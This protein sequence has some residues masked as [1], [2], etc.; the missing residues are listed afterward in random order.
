MERLNTLLPLCDELLSDTETNAD[1]VISMPTDTFFLDPPTEQSQLKA[2][3]VV[4]YFTAWSRVIQKWETPMAYVDLFCGPGKYNDGSLSTPLQIVQQTL[5]DW[6]LSRK[7]SFTF[8]DCDE[9][10]VAS[11]QQS[12]L[13]LD[14]DNKLSKRISYHHL[15]VE[16]DFYKR[17]NIPPGVPVLSFVDPFGYEGVTVRLI[18]RLIANRGSDCIFF[19]N[20]NRINMALSNTKFDEHLESLFGVSRTAELKRELSA[21]SPEL[22]E[23]SILNALVEALLEQKGNYVLPFKFYSAQMKRTSHFIIFVTKHP[24]AC[25]IMKNIMYANSA[26]DSDGVATF[27]LQD[28][29]NFGDRFDQISMFN[30][31]FQSLYDSILHQYQGRTVKVSTLCN[32]ADNDIHS[33]FV[34]KNVKD[35]LRRLEEEGRIVVVDGRKQKSRNGLLNMP[36]A[37]T[38]QF[39]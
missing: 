27:S 13:Q 37:A 5:G 16:Q 29:R 12:I 25:R 10:K 3:I 28:S 4:H 36:D 38:V 7:M 9:A 20:Y 15:T 30:R 33:H 6:D 24:T 23:L 11:L 31:P 18:D 19:F 32:Q 26:K 2:K 39:L 22:R 17:V 14:A 34:S 1:E 35:V 21:L 8:N